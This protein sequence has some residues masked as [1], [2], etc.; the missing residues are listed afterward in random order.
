AIA[1]L[2]AMAGA[3]GTGQARFANDESAIEAALADVVAASVKVEVCN[4][5]DDNC[6]GLVD[7]GFDKGMSCSIGVGACQRNGIKK[8]DAG[9]PAQTLCCVDD[10]SPGGPCLPLLPGAGRT[11]VC[12]G[13]DDNCNGLIDEGVVCQ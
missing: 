7:E 11:E 9:N 3:G 5:K 8:C 6:N 13:I 1:V 10:G 12:N 4:N 2:D